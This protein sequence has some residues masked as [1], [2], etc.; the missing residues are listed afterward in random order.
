MSGGAA[1][2]YEVSWARLFTLHLGSLV[3]ALSALLA[4]YLGGMAA[5]AWAAGR[6]VRHAARPLRWFAALEAGT[7]LTALLVAPGLDLLQPVFR[8]FYRGHL[9][10]PGTS[11]ILPAAAAA[12]LLVLPAA[13]LMGCTLPVLVAGL[14]GTSSTAGRDA[15]RLYAANTLGAVAGVLV[16]GLWLLPAQGIHGTLA[17][18]A[19]TNLAAGILALLLDRKR[20]RQKRAAGVG[21]GARRAWPIPLGLMLAGT[22]SM[23][24]Q[25]GWTR[26]LSLLL[27]SS[28]YAF[29]VILGSFLAGLG[30]GGAFGAR[31]ARHSAAPATALVLVESAAGGACLLALMVLARLPLWLVPP[32]ARLG[33]EMQPVLAVQAAAAGLVAF[34]P[35]FFLGAAFPLAVQV[36]A[37]AGRSPERAAGDAHAASSLGVVAGALLVPLLLPALGLHGM[38][39]A[40]AVSLPVAGAVM[41]IAA[42]TRRHAALL[43]GMGAAVMVTAAGLLLPGWNAEL[44]TSGPFLYAPQY[45]AGSRREGIDLRETVLRRGELLLF[46]E[47]AAATVTVRR[48]PGD[49]LSLQ[50]NGK[51]DASTGGD[52]VTQLLAGHLPALLSPAESMDAL[53]IGLASGVSLGAIERYPFRT[54]DC[55]ELIPEVEEAAELFATASGHAL[56][57]GRLRL[58]LGDGR[59]HLLHS[60]QR[61]DVIASQPTNPWVSGTAA[62]YTRETFQ[63]AWNSLTDGGVFVQWIQGYAL[64]PEDLR[65]VVATFLDVFPGATLW[66]ESPVG[67]D[68]F[69][70]GHRGDTVGTIDLGRIEELL[71]RPAVAADLARAGIGNATDLLAHFVAGPRELGAYSVGAPLQRDDRLALEFS[72]PRALYRRTLSDQV[73]ALRPYRRSPAPLLRGGA[74]EGAAALRTGLRQARAAARREE[75][76]L[77]SIPQGLEA[78]Q[79]DP[80]LTLGLELLRAG[81]RT[82]AEPHLRRAVVADPARSEAR[83]LLGALHAGAGRAREAR[84]ELREAVRLRPDDLSSTALLARLELEAGNPEEAGRLLDSALARSPSDADLLSLAG[85]AA[86]VSGDPQGATAHL[87]RAVV[88]D[89]ELVE[90]WSNLGVARRR[91]DNPAGALQAYRRALE[92]EPENIDARY[93]LGA[94]LLVAGDAATAQQLFVSLVREDPADGES[95]LQLVRALQE[96]DRREEAREQLRRLI[97]LS[98]GAEIERRA[99]ES[100][101]R[102]K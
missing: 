97:D 40:G 85:A 95:V 13:F 61:Y 55:V 2:I 82:A 57:D 34:L 84:M 25:I 54:I 26:A 94:L 38:L 32:M 93:N 14:G 22:A 3:P 59:T 16:A 48:V 89:P 1:L 43:G 63:A 50:I 45:L 69:L 81:L 35:T 44:L 65:S 17:V 74:P 39:L 68:Y 19:S 46:R 10:D 41:G 78:I 15:G 47:G 20:S 83:A 9:S 92:I 64:M 98:P 86:L 96:L 99:R 28:T 102:L 80:E 23:V 66:E 72:A 8:A 79:G 51:T 77:L 75:R 71:R 37:A 60:G 90:A 11:F 36:Q 7:A 76:I 101:A 52:M 5:G 29:T 31:R 33:A 30:L 6:W 12:A 91:D 42:S 53:V 73:R 24:A 70:A 88:L 49:V 87:E 67:G 27:G 100:L 4:A 18:A 21:V 62:L 58:I 56:T